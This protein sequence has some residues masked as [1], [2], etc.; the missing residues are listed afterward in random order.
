TTQTGAAMKVI[1]DGLGQ[2]S[3]MNSQIANAATEQEATST[4]I[5]RNLEEIS[6][7]ADQNFASI[8]QMAG[9]STQLENLA[10]SQETLVRQFVL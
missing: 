9:N 2:I 7:L 8:E 10:A 5:A 6:R 1:A 3:D 4:D